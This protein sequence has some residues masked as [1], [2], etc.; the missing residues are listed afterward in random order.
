MSRDVTDV[1]SRYLEREHAGELSCLACGKDR[2]CQSSG[3]GWPTCL[4]FKALD[5]LGIQTRSKC[6]PREIRDF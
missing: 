4:R 5:Q 3:K 1:T 6:A 2:A